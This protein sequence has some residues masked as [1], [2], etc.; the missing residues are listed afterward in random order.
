MSCRFCQDRFVGT[1]DAPDDLGS[2]DNP[3]KQM[4]LAACTTK[5]IPRNPP[6]WAGAAI[7]SHRHSGSCTSG[8]SCSGR[9]KLFKS[10]V[11]TF[12]CRMSTV[13]IKCRSCRILHSLPSTLISLP[14]LQLCVQWYSPCFSV[15]QNRVLCLPAYFPTTHNSCPALLAPRPFACHAELLGIGE[16]D[17]VCGLT[18]VN[19][20]IMWQGL[21]FGEVERALAKPR[22]PTWQ[23]IGHETPTKNTSL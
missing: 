9:I 21:E 7:E 14:F 23:N 20:G 15:P 13:S 3:T 1:V 16:T 5:N 22:G 18:C 17:L 11:A 4:K 10:F 6:N 8:I 12:S 19:P 2:A